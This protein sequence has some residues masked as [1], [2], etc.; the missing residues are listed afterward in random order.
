MPRPETLIPA[1]RPRAEDPLVTIGIPAYNRPTELERAIRS[2]M[3]Q[4]HSRIE[5]LV[6]DDASP[7]PTVQSVGVAL[8]VEDPRIRL[9]RQERNLGHAANYQWVLD[10]A[11]GEYFMWLA[12]DDWIDPHYV[13][14]CLAVLREDP[15]VAMACGAARYD[16]GGVQV[17]DERPMELISRRPEARVMR[18][19]ARVNMNGPLFSVMRTAELRAIGFPE[20][21]GG[22]W[23]LVAAMAARGTVR[24]LSEV[25]IH[26]SA[27][28][29]GSDAG[30]LAR[31]FR[32]HGTAAE[33]HHVVVAATLAR[34]IVSGPPLF[35]DV[36][37]AARP[38]VALVSA[39]S[40]L[41]RFTLADRVR[42]ILGPHRAARLEAVISRSLRARDR[43]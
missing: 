24:T 19:F 23:V 40:I 36:A 14:R 20:V 15:S 28:G 2:A 3:A 39:A 43:R 18:Y 8:A 1:A 6:S 5:I 32:L 7:D 29:L 38:V 27:G 25:H 16:A 26:R 10:A 9:V 31:S 41:L 37:P 4:A 12:D 30:E 13:D 33:H 17:R 22:D 11:Q 42:A 34:A 35:G 21:V